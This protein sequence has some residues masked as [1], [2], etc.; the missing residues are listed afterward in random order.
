MT[1][2]TLLHR[3]GINLTDML[4]YCNT[5]KKEL[6]ELTGISEATISRYTKGLIMPSLKNLINIAYELDCTV[7]ELID[8]T[9]RID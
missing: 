1:E 6:A 3:F 4:D 7:D 9:E 8:L 2:A 5:T